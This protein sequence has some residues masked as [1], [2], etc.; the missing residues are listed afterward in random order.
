M[1][2]WGLLWFTILLDIPLIHIHGDSKVIIDHIMGS[3]KITNHL[4]LGWLTRIELLWM[5]LN[6]ST[7]RHVD[8]E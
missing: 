6:N 1:A 4:V 7:I 3:I 5:E 8:R 2:L